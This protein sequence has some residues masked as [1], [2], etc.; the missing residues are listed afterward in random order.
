MVVFWFNILNNEDRLPNNIIM[1][2][3]KRILRLIL[4]INGIVLLSIFFKK[5]LVNNC[6]RTSPKRAGIIIKMIMLP[7]ISKKLI[8]NT[9]ISC[10][11]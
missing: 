6:S 10:S 7:V 9:L 5:V 11:S 1:A 2:I 8:V 4:N 3:P